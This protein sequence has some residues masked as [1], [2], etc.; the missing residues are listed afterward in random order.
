MKCA[1]EKYPQKMEEHN[2]QQGIS[3]PVMH[4]ADQAAEKHGILQL[5]YGCI[6]LIGN[7]LVGKFQH[8]AGKEEH[9]HQHYRHA[10]EPPGEGEFERSLRD[11]FWAEMQQ[12]A[13]EQIAIGLPTD[14]AVVGCGKNRI[15]DSLKQVD[16]IGCHIFKRHIIPGVSIAVSIGAL[17][18]DLR[19]FLGS[20][21][22]RSS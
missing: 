3:A 4:V 6:G 15:P 13:V 19:D 17:E 22:L 8:Q 18:P 11:C 2:E 1:G 5:N 20:D 16:S 7:R 21:R 9:T 12:Q 14:P 10:A